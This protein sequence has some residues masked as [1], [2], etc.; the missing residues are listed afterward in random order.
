MEKPN[1]T[2]RADAMEF[3]NL[4]EKT[5]FKT[6]KD[7]GHYY[8]DKIWREAKLRERQECYDWLGRMMGLDSRQAHFSM[9]NYDQCKQAIYH[10]QQLLN[11]NRRLDLD[12]GVEPITPF[13][14]L[15]EY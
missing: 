3:I 2:L 8:F 15:E 6:F 9:F 11:D 4:N 7:K 14:T 1:R 5:K 12:F 13:Y 10:C